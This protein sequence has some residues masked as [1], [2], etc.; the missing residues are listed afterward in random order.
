MEPGQENVAGGDS[1][2]E[3]VKPEAVGGGEVVGPVNVR[4]PRR[5]RQ[6]V[7]KGTLFIL[8]IYLL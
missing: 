2:L 1:V 8:N 5:P 6:W 3:A 4:R 7:R